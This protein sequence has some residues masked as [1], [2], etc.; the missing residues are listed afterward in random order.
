MCGTTP[1][2]KET[3]AEQVQ[4][5]LGGRVRSIDRCIHHIVAAL[6]AGG[7]ETIACCCGHGRQ[8]GRI[9]LADGRVLHIELPAAPHSLID[10]L[11]QAIRDSTPEQRQRV[12]D[13]PSGFIQSAA[14][15]SGC[16]KWR[17]CILG[18]N[19]YGRCEDGY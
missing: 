6:N 16:E 4:L 9:D 18:K 13:N 12:I 2:S 7:V 19:H 17:S 11:A 3:Y 10:G 1:G 8:P 5:P 15:A 14:S